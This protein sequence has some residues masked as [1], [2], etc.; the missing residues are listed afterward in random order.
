MPS[1]QKSII[2]AWPLQLK[3][4]GMSVSKITVFV[5]DI[6]GGPVKGKNVSLRTAVGKIKVIQEITDKE[7]KAK[8][9]L[10]SSTP[11]KAEISAFIGK[12]IKVTQPLSILFK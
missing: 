7:G 2:I 10:S 3:A 5:R 12:S 11:G 9:E 4:D 1:A 6:K 8:F